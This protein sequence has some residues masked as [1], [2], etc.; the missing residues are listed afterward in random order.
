VDDALDTKV[1]LAYFYPG[2]RPSE[3]EAALQGVH[4]IV[5]AGTGLG[6]VSHDL[7]P[8]LH[9]ATRDGVAVLMTTQTLQGRDRPRRVCGMSL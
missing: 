6:H 9:R 2:Q 4:G 7:I 5:I 3:L 8:V 1:A